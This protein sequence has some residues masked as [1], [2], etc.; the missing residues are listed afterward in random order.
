MLGPHAVFK[1]RVNLPFNISKLLALFSMGFTAPA[2][3]ALK[4]SV[5]ER[6]WIDVADNTEKLRFIQWRQFT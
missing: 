1:I 4:I 5:L 6:E 3:G 2:K